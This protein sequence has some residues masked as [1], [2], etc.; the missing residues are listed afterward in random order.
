MILKI[1]SISFLLSL[2]VS[3]SEPEDKTITMSA[4]AKKLSDGKIVECDENKDSSLDVTI[5]FINNLDLTNPG[6]DIPKLHEFHTAVKVNEKGVI[7][8]KNGEQIAF[9]G[10]Q[11]DHIELKNYLKAFLI[12]D[13]DVR[14]VFLPTGFKKDN[15]VYAYIWEVFPDV[16]KEYKQRG[17]KNYGNP[18]HDTVL[19]SKW[20]KPAEQIGH[21]F[22]NR[23]TKIHLFNNSL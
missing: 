19:F 1:L 11:C 17:W 9:A 10:M 8:L 4:C 14:V 12:K 22:H 13:K 7:E 6:P 3:C 23:F 2:I 16:E 5:K 15:I 20:C 21:K 18:T